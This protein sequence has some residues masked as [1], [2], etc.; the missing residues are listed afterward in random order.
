MN[1]LKEQSVKVPTEEKKLV[2]IYSQ[3]NYL[4]N[5]LSKYIYKSSFVGN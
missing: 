5:N 1:H 4:N 3:W 2:H